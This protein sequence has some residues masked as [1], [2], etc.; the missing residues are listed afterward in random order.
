MNT[1]NFSTTLLVDQTP[2]EVFSA[3]NNVRDWWFGEIEGDM[4][5]LNDEFTYR[6][7]TFHYS[8]QK[9]TEFIPNRK[10]VWLVTESSLNFVEHKNEW[11]CTKIIFDITEKDGKTQIRFTHKGLV[12]KSE[13]YNQC[14][15]AWSNI[16]SHNLY[17]LITRKEK[18]EKFISI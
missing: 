4:Q 11:T 14:S 15:N 7:E 8:K 13:C 17:K 9:L 6:Y 5:K 10:I 1:Q 16:I 18:A 2:G 12:P 3:I